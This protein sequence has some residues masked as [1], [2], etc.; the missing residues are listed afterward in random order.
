MTAFHQGEKLMQPAQYDQF[1]ADARRNAQE[2]IESA[3]A[4]FGLGTHGR[5]EIDLPTARIRFLDGDGV[6][7]VQADLQVAGSWSTASESWLWG[8]D[9]ESVPETA[10]ARLAAVQAFG[11]ENDI[12]KLTAS[13]EPCDEGEAWSMASIAAHLLDARCVYRVARPTNHLFL[14]L[15][16]IR[17]VG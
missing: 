3:K 12:E 13:F 6:E 2:K 9:N 17:S 8:W 16:S 7:R 15:F 10:S 4:E 1:V 5:Y 11:Q 14:L